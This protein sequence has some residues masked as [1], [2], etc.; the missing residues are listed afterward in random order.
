[1]N[2]CLKIINRST[3]RTGGPSPRTAPRVLRTTLVQSDINSRLPVLPNNLRSEFAKMQQFIATFPADFL[4]CF[5]KLQKQMADLLRRQPATASV[6]TQTEP[7]LVA[8]PRAAATY[9]LLSASGG[10][11]MILD[12]MGIEYLLKDIASWP[13]HVQDNPRVQALLSTRGKPVTAT[14]T[15]LASTLV[16]AA[17]ASLPHASSEPLSLPGSSTEKQTKTTPIVP[18]CTVRSGVKIQLPPPP[19]FSRIADDNDV[20][21]W[22]GLIE[23]A[24][25]LSCVTRTC[26]YLLLLTCLTRIPL[27]TGNLTN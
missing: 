27:V 3:R 10:V 8:L 26:G 17:D 20:T 6:A 24:C 19:K 16:P 14:D 15:A 13:A 22:L 5:A 4:A 11:D 1:M 18:N 21:E 23:E 2:K 12:A 9:N 25:M 7:P